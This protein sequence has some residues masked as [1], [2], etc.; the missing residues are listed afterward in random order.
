MS[1]AWWSGSR[2][3]LHEQGNATAQ[4]VNRDIVAV[5]RIVEGLD[6][7]AFENI[8]D[9]DDPNV[10]DREIVQSVPIHRS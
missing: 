1:A 2:N 8:T 3:G 7:V 5:Q 9:I 4:H 6:V 10:G